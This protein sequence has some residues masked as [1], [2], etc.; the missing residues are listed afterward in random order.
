LYYICKRRGERA[1][2]L[3]ELVR[4]KVAK[5]LKGDGA[6]VEGIDGRCWTPDG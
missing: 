5:V 3:V 2:E 1:R 4:L 6:S